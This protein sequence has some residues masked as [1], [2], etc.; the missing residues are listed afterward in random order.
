MPPLATIVWNPAVPPPLIFAVGGLLALVSGWIY[1]RS[2][3]F[4]PWKKRIVLLALRLLAI[5]AIC[6]FLFSPQREEILP[7]THADRVATIL[8]DTSRSMNE[9]DAQGGIR[10]L[11]AAR[12]LLRDSGLAGEES[13]IGEVFLHQFDEDSRA[14][15]F[16]DLPGLSAEGKTT[17]I[18]S[19]V[20]SALEDIGNRE[21]SVGLFL[22]TD[23]HD[24]ERIPAEQT[25]KLA[26]IRKTP[27]FPVPFGKRQ[28]VPDV[29]LELTSY[30]P[31]T[32]VDQQMQIGAAARLT[33]GS[34]RPLRIELV[35]EGTVVAERKVQATPG[36]ESTVSFTVKE[37]EAGQFEYIVRASALPEERDLENNEAFTF[38]NVTDARIPVLLLEGSPHW[39][40]TFLKRTLSANERI[41]L[42]T[43][44]SLAENKPVLWTNAESG[45]ATG[46]GSESG[47]ESPPGT[48]IPESQAD[49]AAFPLVIAGRK[50]ERLL[51]GE[52]MQNLADA[53]AQDGITL[54]FARGEPG[55]SGALDELAP[56]GWAEGAAGPVRVTSRGGGGIVPVD[57]LGTAPGGADSLP[58]LPFVRRLEEPKT[59]AAVEGVV[60]DPGGSGEVPAFV[61]RRVEAGQ[62]L[63]IS[64][65]GLWRWSLHQESEP[66]NNL[67]DRFWNQLLLNLFARSGATASEH[68]QLLVG[69]ANLLL[70]QEAAFTLHPGRATLAPGPK[71][72][73]VRRGDELMRR[74]TL[75]PD[76]RGAWRGRFLPE[77]PGRYQ[78]RLPLDDQVVQARFAVARQNREITEVSPDH[79][80]LQKLAD[81]SGGALLDP[82]GLKAAREQL[83]RAAAAESEAPPLVER[84][85]LWDRGT[86]F[87]LFFAV[88][89]L[90]WF[91]RRRW[92]MV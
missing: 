3:K 18:H 56:A 24:F 59:L 28:T 78:V 80:Y 47:P 33:G 10:R 54:L 12:I 31:A 40:S 1:L 88:L 2:V 48:G 49:F 22:F 73:V 26:R 72:A 79:A 83:A 75:A 70:G 27:L 53:V 85:S 6:L 63:A 68:P 17:R 19:A 15:S 11:D 21:N 51:S 35:R 14:L 58:E 45:T 7:R 55:E 92:G 39:D 64:V 23:G 65:G 20:R 81:L 29:S 60:A 57:L 13:G 74:V 86:V 89:G 90:E 84:E 25:A 9:Q 62:V 77:E 46:T 52:A 43:A 36:S 37:P 50:L 42:T 82:D 16:D 87:Y 38:V 61:H 8:L 4:L 67:Y 71:E 66:A 32:F 34:P 30:R 41:E 69:S 5:A 44:I 91:L 76:D